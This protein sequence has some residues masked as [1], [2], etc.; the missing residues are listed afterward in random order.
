MGTMQHIA[1]G[2]SPVSGLDPTSALRPLAL[3]YLRRTMRFT[4]EE[5]SLLIGYLD[6]ESTVYVQ[7]FDYAS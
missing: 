7:S 1:E 5:I 3:T 6:L 2:Y 4:K